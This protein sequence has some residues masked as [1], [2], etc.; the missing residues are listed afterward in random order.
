V[1]TDGSPRDRSPRGGRYVAILTLADQLIS[2]LSNFALGVLIARVGGASGLG[3]FGVAFLVWLAVLGINRAMVA[4]PMTVRG[5]V[6][7]KSDLSRGCAASTVL[8]GVAAA[9]IAA[10]SGILLLSGLGTTTAV[11]L[12]ALAPWLPGLLAQDYCR[13]MAFRLKRPGLAL[14]SDS[15]FACVQAALT[16]VFLLLGLEGTAPL[17][18]AWGLGA[19]VGAAACVTIMKLQR[20]LQGGLRHLREL[21]SDSRWFLGEFAT[22]FTS[23]Q[24]YMFLLPLILTTAL[25]GQYRAGAALIGPV[26]VVFLAGAN[27]GLPG[28]VQHFR[29]GGIPRLDGYV[30]R[31]TAGVFA[32]TLPYCAVVALLAEPLLKLVYGPSFTDAAVVARLIAIDYALTAVG[33]GCQAALKAT[34]QIRRLWGTRILS[35][36]VSILA[37]VVLAYTYGLAGAAWASVIAAATQVGGVMVGYRQVRRQLLEVA[38]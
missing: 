6:D 3:A 21:W 7:A 24:G 4:E 36:S 18:A 37:T 33:F 8:G 30:G 19:I 13:S 22:A 20:P 23:V 10:V 31:L 11:A 1:S 9:G 16:V 28:C 27:V 12:I 34:N 35:G 38:P 2:S 14:L 17:I 15:V 29:E 25:F 32:L 26:I 5:P